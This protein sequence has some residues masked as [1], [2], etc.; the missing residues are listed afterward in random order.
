MLRRI[1]TGI[2]LALTSCTAIPAVAAL[3]S[4]PAGGSPPAAVQQCMNGGWRTLKDAAGQSFENEGQCISYA[5]HHP[6]GLADLAGPSPF[7]GTPTLGFKTNGC[8]FGYAAFDAIYPGSSSVGDVDLHI[9][10]CIPSS[11]TSYAGSFT[12]TTG[13]GTISGNA[14]GPLTVS[15]GPDD[16]ALLTFQLSL[17]V[18]AGSGSFARTSGSLQFSASWEPVDTPTSFVG[19][20]TVP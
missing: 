15:F 8:A 10:G 3:T 6:V 5:I 19:S 18:D 2:V 12:M 11:L 7:T 9:A 20:V 1:I 17:S 13:V 4:A 14:S 16:Q